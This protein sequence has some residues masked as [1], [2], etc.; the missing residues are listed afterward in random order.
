MYLLRTQIWCP[1]Q[2]PMDVSIWHVSG[3]THSVANMFCRRSTGEC[4]AT[5]LHLIG[6]D[7][8][9]T[10]PPP[11]DV[12]HTLDTSGYTIFWCLVHYISMCIYTL[13]YV[14][15]YPNT[16]CVHIQIRA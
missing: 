13:L 11:E 9:C 7:L 3:V 5:C 10:Y 2:V 4:V 15:M 6:T 1:D 16:A 8:W 12:V 14:Y